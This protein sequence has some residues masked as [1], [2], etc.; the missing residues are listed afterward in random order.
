MIFTPPPFCQPKKVHYTK[1]TQPPARWKTAMKGLEIYTRKG[2]IG[3]CMGC[4]EQRS[5]FPFL[6]MMTRHDHGR[7]FRGRAGGNNADM[8]C[9][10]AR[11]ERGLRSRA[12]AARENAPARLLLFFIQSFY[13]LHVL[14]IMLDT[15]GS[16]YNLQAWFCFQLHIVCA[17]TVKLRAVFQSIQ[18]AG[19]SGCEAAISVLPSRSPSVR[20]PSPKPDWRCTTSMPP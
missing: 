2:D 7:R 11:R 6:F 16:V 8:G 19:G 5:L 1:Q 9:V 10:Q 18:N 13:I 3:V 15:L 12:G 4:V 17:V 20:Q 14:S